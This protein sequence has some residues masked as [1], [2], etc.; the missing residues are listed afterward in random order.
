MAASKAAAPK[1]KNWRMVKK[2]R[3]AAQ[4]VNATS[5]STNGANGTGAHGNGNGSTKKAEAAR[6]WEHAAKLDAKAPWRAV[7]SEFE[8]NKAQTLD[9]FRSRA[10]PVGI[11]A[12]AV[13]RFCELSGSG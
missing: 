3:Q 11:G 7:A 8:I 1:K 4:Q 10:L 9:A 12:D 5:A 13:A 6:L 2:D